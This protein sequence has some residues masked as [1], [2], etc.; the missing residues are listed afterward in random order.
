MR[1]PVAPLLALLLVPLRALADATPT[2][3]TTTTPSAAQHWQQH[4][5]NCHGASGR[6]DTPLGIRLKLADLTRAEWKSGPGRDTV[7]LRRVI[8]DG[9]RGTAMRGYAAKLSAAELE[10]LV[11]Y[12]RA[13]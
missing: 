9:T 2:T 13:L 8:A 12:V 5:A 6:A 4:C 1:L 11:A 3:G 7:A 10:A